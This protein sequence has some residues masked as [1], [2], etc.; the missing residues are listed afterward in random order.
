MLLSGSISTDPYKILSEQKSFYH[1]LYKSTNKNNE[2]S[3]STSS[4]LNNL[5][6]PK[7]SK[8]QQTTREGKIYP[9]ECETALRSF[10]N[11]KALGND[12]IPIEFYK[13]FWSL[14]SNSYMNCVN[15]SFEKGEISSS[16]KQAIITLIE[17]KDKDRSLL[18]N[19]R[20]ISL[21][22]VDAKII[23]KV[24]ATRIKNI[25]PYIIHQNQTG[26]IKYRFI[27]ETVRS[28]TL[29]NKIFQV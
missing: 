25:L 2:D 4:F 18:E 13:T 9:N 7:L 28:I 8:E 6:I 24:I 23:S 20:P 22:N 11:N 10:E 26:Y 19:W 16:M 12:G 1:N 21:V 17:K 15:K 29:L 3:Q 5:N 27:G 14:I